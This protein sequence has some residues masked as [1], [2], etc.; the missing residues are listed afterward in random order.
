LRSNNKIMKQFLL[1]I[2]II[3]V[4]GNL[5]AQAP[6]GM[7]GM[8]AGIKQP[9]NIGHVY[10]KLTD[11]DGK[12]LSGASVLLMQKKTDT[13]TKKI[14]Q[15]LV[16][17]IITKSNGDF[18][19]D[20]LPVMSDLQL[21]ISSSGYK[22]M[23]Q[24]ISFLPKGQAGAMPSSTG[25]MPSFEK[26]LGNIKL[27]VDATQLQNVT[28]AVSSPAVRLSAD[29][30]IFNVEKKHHECW[31]DGFGRNAKRSFCKCGY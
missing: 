5:Y 15:I 30:K 18:N 1:L 11:A 6:Q 9:A 27:V 13:A 26:D 21:K 14:K 16:K 17:G 10:G 23:E 2:A 19:F 4:T 20:E 8:G 29:K 12:P 25:G 31:R 24:N 28:V 3:I 22:A 7:P